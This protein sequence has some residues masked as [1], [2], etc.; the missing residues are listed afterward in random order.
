MISVVNGFV[1]TSSCDVAKAKHG[2]DPDAPP[3]APPGWTDKSEDASGF[4]RRPATVFGGALKDLQTANAVTPV[5]GTS[6]SAASGPSV[7]ILV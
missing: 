1:C 5:D 3:G 2:T 4:D 6:P 7:D